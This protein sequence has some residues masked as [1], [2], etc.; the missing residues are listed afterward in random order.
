MVGLVIAWDGQGMIAEIR[1]GEAINFWETWFW[2]LG[3]LIA[4]IA[5]PFGGSPMSSLSSCSG[6]LER[7][8]PSRFCMLCVFPPRSGSFYSF[9]FGSEIIFLLLGQVNTQNACPFGHTSTFFIFLLMQGSL[10][11]V[12]PP[13]FFLWYVS[14]SQ[15]GLLSIFLIIIHPRWGSLKQ[16]GISWVWN[17][18]FWICCV[19]LP[20]V[21]NHS[22]F[23]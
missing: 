4:K 9:S 1:I 14:P 12:S 5:F 2:I 19:F 10:G 11:V 3:K 20:H 18:W 17:P 23:F 16:L 21:D 22:S 6:R 8:F 7:C 13:W 15:F